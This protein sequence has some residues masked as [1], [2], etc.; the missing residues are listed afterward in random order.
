[1]DLQMPEMDGLEATRRIRQN[2]P[3][4]SGPRIIAM[5]ANVTKDDRLSC[6]EAGMD[7]FLAKPIRVNELVAALS[8]S[9]PASLNAASNT[10]TV[11]SHTDSPSESASGRVPS[12]GASFEPA[13]IDQLLSLVSG[14]RMALS[15]LIT[16]YLNDTVALLQ[17]LRKAVETDNPGLLHRAGHSLKSSSRDFGALRLSALGQQLEQIGKGQ[18]T[19]GAAE[20]VAQAEAERESLHVTL[21]QIRKGL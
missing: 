2:R 19:S 6:F 18:R 4:G 13:V 1:M 8:R 9:L 17:D 21:E 11:P 15:E 14:N 10:K 3:K 5:T 7:D 20:L 12:P 16:S